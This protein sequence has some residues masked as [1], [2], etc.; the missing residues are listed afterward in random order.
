MFDYVEMFYNLKRKH[1]RNGMLSPVEFENQQKTK[2]EGVYETRGYS[3]IGLIKTSFAHQNTVY[4]FDQ[5]LA[6]Q[7][8]SA[9]EPFHKKAHGQAT[10]CPCKK[11]CFAE[12][13]FGVT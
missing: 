8:L 4:T 1:V 3:H 7:N 13:L 9:Q 2:H 11:V 6:I 10:A 12:I 5:S